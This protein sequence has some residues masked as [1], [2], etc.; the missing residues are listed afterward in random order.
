[1]RRALSRA[2]E[3]ASG[4][5]AV[6]IFIKK[7]NKDAAGVKCIFIATPAGGKGSGGGSSS[8]VTLTIRGFL[9]TQSR[10]LFSMVRPFTNDV[11]ASYAYAYGTYLGDLVHQM[12]TNYRCILPKKSFMHARSQI[13]FGMKG[14]EPTTKK[15]GEGGEWLL[16]ARIGARGTIRMVHRIA[17]KGDEKKCPLIQ[18]LMLLVQ[19]FAHII[20]SCRLF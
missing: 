12:T 7:C 20:A 16:N 15:G 19:G 2:S 8:H 5:V 11:A 13:F 9:L 18:R 14:A 3:R 6:R 4:S 10:W 1:M 17:Q